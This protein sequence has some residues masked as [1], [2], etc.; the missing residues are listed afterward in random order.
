[1]DPQLVGI[2][3]VV[4]LAGA[5]YREFLEPALHERGISLS[6]PM[7]GLSQGW[8]LAWLNACLHG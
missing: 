3:A 1:M 6:V 8:Q 5:Q 7:S 2:D 4:F